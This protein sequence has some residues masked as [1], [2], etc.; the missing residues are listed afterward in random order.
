MPPS[1]VPTSDDDPESRLSEGVRTFI[2]LLLF[3]HLFAL[4][5]VFFSNFEGSD[6][7]SELLRRMK[8]VVRPYLYPLWLDRPYHYHLTYAEPLDFDHYIEVALTPKGSSESTIIRLPED[9]LGIGLRRQRYQRLAWH[10]ARRTESQTPDDLLPL[11]IGAGLIKQHTAARAQVRCFRKRPLFLD[12]V[13]AGASTEPPDERL[14]AAD[15]F[16]LPGNALPQ[17]NKIGEARDVAPVKRPSD[18]GSQGPPN[19]ESQKGSSSGAGDR[20]APLRNPLF[21]NANSAR[22]ASAPPRSPPTEK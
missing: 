16:F 15:V 18:S 4:G 7:D 5:L 10:F 14:Y 22:P 20:A 11:T 9:D 12:E 3:V 6:W 1:T 21:P 13:R 2:S 19:R 17:L 8:I